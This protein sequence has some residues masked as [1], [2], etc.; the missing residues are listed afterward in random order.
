MKVEGLYVSL[1]RN[2]TGL[3]LV[4]AAVTGAGVLPVFSTATTNRN[5]NDFA[6]VRAGLNY[7]FGTF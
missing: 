4:G 1:D 3:P 5:T 7:K 2:R 6:V